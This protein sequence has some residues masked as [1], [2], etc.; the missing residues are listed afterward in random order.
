MDNL[1]TPQEVAD[2]TGVKLSTIT[3]WR[4]THTDKIPYIKVGMRVMYSVD[5]V[6]AWMNKQR[7]EQNG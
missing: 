7:V 6:K 3:T 4:S 2:I 5:D 1:I